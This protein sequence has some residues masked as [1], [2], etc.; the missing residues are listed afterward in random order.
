MKAVARVLIA[1]ALLAAAAGDAA[2]VPTSFT[3]TG[4]LL[5]GEAPLDGDI[6]LDLAL[7]ETS[8]GGTPVWAENHATTAD[9]GMV[10][11]AL[12]GETEL[13]PATF[14]GGDLWL[15]ITVNGTELLPRFQMRSVPYAMRSEISTDSEAIGGIPADQVQQVLADNCAVGSAIRDIAPDGTV[16]CEPV[17]GGGSGVPSGAVM[18]FDVACPTGWSPYAALTGRVPVGATAN[19]GDPVGTQLSAGG[20]RTITTVPPHTHLVNPASFTTTGTDGTHTHTATAST[21]LEHDHP[22]DLGNG[23]YGTSRV[24]GS[25]SASQDVTTLPIDNDGAHSHTIT[26]T[27]TNSGHNHAVDVPETESTNTGDNV[28][29]GAVDVTMPYLQL[30]ACRKD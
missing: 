11:V 3:F 27:T 25:S 17:G 5:D 2:A 21:S 15:S 28:A 22:I 16:T 9:Q 10:S 13:D 8:N 18:M 30:R 12:G 29:A 19:I 6:T 7:Y 24:Q 1:G 20:T 26:V 4:R 23:G 14:G